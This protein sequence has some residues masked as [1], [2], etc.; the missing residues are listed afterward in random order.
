MDVL[1]RRRLLRAA[2]ALS[3]AAL[4][5]AA[6]GR[7]GRGLA[8]AA[9]GSGPTEADWRALAARLDGDVVRR[10]D[11]EHGQVKQLFNTRSCSRPF[12]LEGKVK[13]S[14]QRLVT[15]PGRVVH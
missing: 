11:D 4:A 8:A 10:S 12:F 5:V 13:W 3:G 6:G 1:P 2:S 9:S 14:K 7:V 15:Q